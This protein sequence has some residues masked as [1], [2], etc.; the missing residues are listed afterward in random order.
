M[1]ISC[2]IMK[3][4]VCG[5]NFTECH[6]AISLRTTRERLINEIENQFGSQTVILN[7]IA[8]VVFFSLFP[9]FVPP[10][11]LC[12]YSP[13]VTEGLI[14]AKFLGGTRLFWRTENA[15]QRGRR[16]GKCGVL[17]DESYFLLVSS[18]LHSNRTAPER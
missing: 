15:T 10:P 8:R 5:F 2:H 9:F 14:V 7:N 3:S 12:S 11:L 17:A 16:Q 4:M 6:S 13:S 1:P 18:I